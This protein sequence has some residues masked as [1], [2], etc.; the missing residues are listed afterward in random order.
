LDFP[1]VSAASTPPPFSPSGLFISGEHMSYQI[2][3]QKVAGVVIEANLAL[4]DKGFN[5]G[6]IILGLGELAG[7][8]IV[9]AADTPVQAKELV[10]VV[11]GHMERTITIGAHVA[12]K[13][14]I[15][16]V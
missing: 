15:E 6:E 12:G 9:E 1:N 10:K 16:K 4:S 13:S 11:I 2:D 3:Q 14:I 8:I 5:H 7:R